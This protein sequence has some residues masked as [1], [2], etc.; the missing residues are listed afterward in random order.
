LL[1]PQFKLSDHAVGRLRSKGKR[2]SDNVGHTV[3]DRR[4][5]DFMV[6]LDAPGCGVCW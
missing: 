6:D 5:F 4:E 1:A 2:G 3:R